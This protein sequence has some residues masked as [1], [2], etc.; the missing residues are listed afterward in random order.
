MEGVE[1]F[2]IRAIGKSNMEGSVIIAV[3]IPSRYCF[4]HQF[5]CSKLRF[6]TSAVIPF[7]QKLL[8]TSRPKG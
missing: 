8:G 7:Q 4:G 2:G 1:A 3:K 6:N 5:K